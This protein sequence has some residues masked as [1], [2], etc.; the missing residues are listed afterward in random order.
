[1]I[2]ILQIPVF[3]DLTDFYLSKVDQHAV[4]TCQPKISDKDTKTTERYTVADNGKCTR[5]LISLPILQWVPSYPGAHTHWYPLISSTHWASFWHGLLAHSKI[6]VFKMEQ[7][8]HEIITKRSV[9]YYIAKTDFSSQNRLVSFNIS[10]KYNIGLMVHSCDATHIRK[11]QGQGKKDLH[12]IHQQDPPLSPLKHPFSSLQCHLICSLLFPTPW[13]SSLP[14]SHPL[15]LTPQAHFP[16]TPLDPL[17]LLSHLSTL[18][19]LLLHPFAL[20]FP[21]NIFSLPSTPSK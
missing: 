20:T 5:D 17:S 12:I 18:L 6:S 9:I 11:L 3:L 1:M 13:H 4:Q 19:S 15:P 14:P 10:C 8:I 2:H 21:S 16:L 7:D